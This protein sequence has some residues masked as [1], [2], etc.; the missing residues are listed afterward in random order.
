MRWSEITETRAGVLYH[1]Y[2]DPE[3]FASAM[4]RD[5]MLGTT[6]QRWWDDGG[7]LKDDHPDYDTSNWMKG[8]SLTRDPIFAMQWGR[9]IIA[10]DPAIIRQRHKIIP[11]NWGYSIPERNGGTDQDHKRE[12]EEFVVTHK[13]DQYRFPDGEMDHKRFRQPEGEV[14]GL[15]RYLRG[16][17]VCKSMVWD[18]PGERHPMSAYF[19]NKMREAGMPIEQVIAHPMFKGYFQAGGYPV[20]VEPKFI[21]LDGPPMIHPPRN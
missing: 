10:V 4:E 17:W 14:K 8:L 5:S 19:Q 20:R 16:I 21:K 6:T 9:I 2:K 12:R 1:G 18:E 13:G 15:S 7:R 11:F 3:H